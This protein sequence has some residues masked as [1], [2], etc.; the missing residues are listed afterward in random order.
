MI[1]PIMSAS[2]ASSVWTAVLLLSMATAGHQGWAA[3][4]FTIVSDI[5]PRR[6]VSSVVGICGF[7][8][9]IGGMVVSSALGFILQRTGSYVPIFLLAGTS[10]FVALGLIHWSSPRMAAVEVD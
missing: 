6:A 9:S 8:G 7:G 1:A 4:I 3:N 5:Y 10:Y 2:Q